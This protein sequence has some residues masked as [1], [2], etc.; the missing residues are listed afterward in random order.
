MCAGGTARRAVVDLFHD[1]SAPDPL[2]CSASINSPRPTT[3]STSRV[4]ALRLPPGAR[5]EA[6]QPIGDRQRQA[7]AQRVDPDHRIVDSCLSD[8]AQ[9]CVQLRLV[10]SLNNHFPLPCIR[11]RASGKLLPRGLLPPRPPTV[12][13]VTGWI[14]RH[15]ATL[16]E[17]DRA[18]GGAEAGH[19]LHG[20]T[21]HAEGGDTS[22][23]G[24][25]PG[26]PSPPL[27]RGPSGHVRPLSVP[28]GRIRFTDSVV[29]T[30]PGTRRGPLC[31]ICSSSS[32]SIR[33]NS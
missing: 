1:T 33:T 13:Q 30:A 14:T 7:P 29:A 9:P 16:T 23:A 21:H 22:P 25:G 26:F 11:C 19:A 12:R 3:R 10:P 8:V 31:V 15:P 6:A 18:G 28:C 4:P 17:V 2:R 5:H 24:A 20:G 27:A 32:V